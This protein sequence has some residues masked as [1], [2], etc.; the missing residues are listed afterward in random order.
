MKKYRVVF[1]LL[2]LFM[3]VVFQAITYAQSSPIMYFC[4]KH[5][6]KYGEIGVSNKFTVGTLTLVIKSDIP[7][8]NGNFQVQY[9]K[10]NSGSGNFEY[11]S[12]SSIK[13]AN[14]KKYFDIAFK[15]PGIYR[16]FLLSSSNKT[17]A[18]A[19]IEIIR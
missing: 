10:Y 13:G 2:F 15:E 16:V 17:I 6:D 3:P 9:D 14:N 1:L 12:K 19:L 8:P 11:Y 18:S 5:S 7:L 4:E